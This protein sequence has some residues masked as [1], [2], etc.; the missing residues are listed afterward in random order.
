MHSNT[1]LW[2]HICIYCLQVGR[3]HCLCDTFVAIT[4]SIALS[5]SLS[6]YLSRSVSVCLSLLH[7]H[8]CVCVCVCVS[9]RRYWLRSKVWEILFVL[10]FYCPVNPMGSCR[11]R[12]VYLS[13]LLLGRLSPLSEFCADSFARNWQQ[14]FLNQRRGVRDHRQYIVIKSP[15]KN[16]AV[17][18]G[19]ES[20]TSWLPV[21]RTSSWTIEAG[22]VWEKIYHVSYLTRNVR[23]GIFKYVRPTKAQNSLHI[24]TVCS[25]SPLSS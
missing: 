2:L 5:L 12:S 7:K 18:T 3:L 8:T 15:W 11:A 13:I 9:E 16:V 1:L 4:E 23:K 22:I 25:E 24:R 19:I 6:L 20:T 21:G 14:P 17:P 10:R